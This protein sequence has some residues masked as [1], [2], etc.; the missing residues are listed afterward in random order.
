MNR[1]DSEIE[2]V[3]GLVGVLL[4]F[5]AAY[6]TVAV[7]AAA[8]LLTRRASQVAADRASLRSDLTRARDSLVGL[9]ILAL[10][11]LLLLIPLSLRVIAE[12]SP[13][14]SFR[15]GRAGLLLVEALLTVSL[16]A[17][18]IFHIRISRRIREL[19]AQGVPR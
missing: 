16:I 17:A 2:G 11:V 8:H 5:V 18:A 19:D 1:L 6:A 7:P 10:S 15:T 13:R 3:F 4:V 12:F 14:G 9:V